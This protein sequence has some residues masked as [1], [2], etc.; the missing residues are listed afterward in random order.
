[1]IFYSCV[2]R[3]RFKRCDF[4]SSP[5][6]LMQLFATLRNAPGEDS[7]TCLNNTR[8]KIRLACFL[9]ANHFS[10]EHWP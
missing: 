5:L 8:E 3:G 10:C 6:T 2:T 9:V 4:Y 7:D 1:M